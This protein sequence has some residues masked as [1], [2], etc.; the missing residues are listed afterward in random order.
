M[1]KLAALPSQTNEKNSFNS[2]D[3]LTP[4]YVADKTRVLYF[5]IFCIGYGEAYLS[6]VTQ[7]CYCK[8]LRTL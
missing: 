1:H 8:L 2:S 4:L 3:T 5:K 6:Y 7:C